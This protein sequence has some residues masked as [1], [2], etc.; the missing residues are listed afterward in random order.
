MEHFEPKRVWFD[1]N[2]GT[3]P[4]TATAL[5]FALKH[6]AI[7]VVGIS[8][9]GKSQDR[10]RQEAK[11]LLHHFKDVDI[12][13]FLGSEVDRSAIDA[14]QPDATITTGSLTNIG[15]LVL[16]E[17]S[18]GKLHVLGGAFRTVYNRGKTIIAEKNILSDMDSARVV[19]TQYKDIVISTLEASSQLILDS[20]TKDKIEKSYPFLAARYKGYEKYLRD[21]YGDDYSA[22]IVSDVLPV[23]DVLN[24]PTICRE[25][26]E[27]KF[28][29]DGTFYSTSPL[30][31]SSEPIEKVNENPDSIPMPVVKHEAI[32]TVNS[33]RILEELKS[34]L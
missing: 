10:R 27:F 31:D 4:A 12:P 23:C 33:T 5:L 32:R 20:T 2:I 29:S 21:Q 26:V 9:S 25:V 16:D 11:A 7:D 1:I 17:A 34:I 19:L 18:L 13:I 30:V 24:I 28:Q 22:L 3:N 8:I 6:P 15:K 14:T